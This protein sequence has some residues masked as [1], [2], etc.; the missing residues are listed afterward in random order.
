VTAPIGPFESE[1]SARGAAHAVVPPGPGFAVLSAAQNR[2][3]L[4]RACSE[5]GVSLGAFDARILSWLSGFEDSACAV[6]AG[7]VWRAHAAGREE[8]P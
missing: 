3:L 5:A 8:A 2:E 7:L 4:V 6:I 1:H